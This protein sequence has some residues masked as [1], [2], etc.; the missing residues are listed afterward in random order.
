[1]LHGTQRGFPE[2]CVVA[3]T[4]ASLKLAL[5]SS[6]AGSALGHSPLDEHAVPPADPAAVHLHVVDLALPHQPLAGQPGGP[7]VELRRQADAGGWRVCR[8]GTGRQEVGKGADLGARTA[9]RGRGGGTAAS[10]GL[11]DFAQKVSSLGTRWNA[12]RWRRRRQRPLRPAPHI[13]LVHRIVHRPRRPPTHP[14]L[15]TTAT[16]NVHA[17]ASS[18]LRP[19][20]FASLQAPPPM[21]EKRCMAAARPT[22]QDSPGMGRENMTAKAGGSQGGKRERRMPTVAS[23]VPAG[24]ACMEFSRRVRSMM[25]S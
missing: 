4:P 23:W 8:A 25:A 22:W 12:G 10:A 2:D 13:C 21:V 5:R 16:L 18:Q 19:Q 20:M 11:W 14:T 9:Q 24:V 3:R 1:M 15:T 7:R 6:S 17:H